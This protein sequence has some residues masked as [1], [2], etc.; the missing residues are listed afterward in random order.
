M[1]EE[2]KKRKI[3]TRRNFMITGGVLTTGLVVGVAGLNSHV[4]KTNYVNLSE[5]RAFLF[6]KSNVSKSPPAP[7]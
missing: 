4:N 3:F 1:S 6:F 5:P 7:T 2:I